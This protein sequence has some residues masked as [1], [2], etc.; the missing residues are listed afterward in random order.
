MGTIIL[1][2]ISSGLLVTVLTLL[3]GMIWTVMGFGGLSLSTLVDLGLL[4]SCVAGGYKSSK[5]AQNWLV[6]GIVGI[7]YVCV[8]ILLLA[9]FFPVN[10]LGVIQVLA[11]GGIIGLIAG[12][13]GAGGAGKQTRGLSRGYSQSQN[14][15]TPGSSWEK[16]REN[17]WGELTS[18]RND[19]DG[20]YIP[21]NEP[22][23]RKE[24]ITNGLNQMEGESWED[25]DPQSYAETKSKVYDRGLRASQ[26]V[27]PGLTS[28]RT[29]RPWWEED[30]G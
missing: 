19:L 20:N 29:S 6:G 3:A 9:L 23:Q 26:E 11:E 4:I 7:G 28:S 1:R 10:S 21:D 15:Y 25:I 5:E 16:S 14:F 8:G 22:R 2:G 24:R 17:S 27:N 13:I 18:Y 12:A 30:I